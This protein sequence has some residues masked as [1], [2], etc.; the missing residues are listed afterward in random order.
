MKSYRVQFKIWA[1]S[2]FT[3]PFSWSRWCDIQTFSYGSDAYLLQGKSNKNSNA[4]KN[5][6]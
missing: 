2:Y 5:L 3:H 1:Y 4:K 6:E